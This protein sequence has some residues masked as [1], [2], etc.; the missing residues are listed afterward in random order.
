MTPQPNVHGVALALGRRGL[1]V[2]GPS[3][4]GKT[5]LALA[6]IAEVFARGVFARLVSDD[7]VLLDAVN[8]RLVAT[9]PATIAGLAEIH[10]LGPRPAPHLDAAVV[11]LVVELVADAPRFQ[12]DARWERAGAAAPLLRLPQ[13]NVA[14]CLPAVLGRLDILWP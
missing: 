11:D 4:A 13:R 8:G 9:A 2:T 6:L 7:Q 1:L 14:A 5:T 12:E 10:G 3:G